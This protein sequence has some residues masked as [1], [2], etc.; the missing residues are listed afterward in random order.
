M[1][2]TVNYAF[3]EPRKYLYDNYKRYGREF[4]SREELANLTEKHHP[5]YSYVRQQFNVTTDLKHQET[6]RDEPELGGLV[7][8]NKLDTLENYI[9]GPPRRPFNNPAGNYVII[10]NE[11]IDSDGWDLAAHILYI[12]WRDYRILN[13]FLILSCEKDEVHLNVHTI[14]NFLKFI[15]KHF[16]LSATMIRL[17]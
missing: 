10:I 4:E 12:L 1:S 13:A 14:L 7:F 17:R 11:K 9:V 16:R 15:L 8:V 3:D 5:H 2:Y 6:R